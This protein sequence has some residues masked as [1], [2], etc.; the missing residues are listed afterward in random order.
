[1]MLPGFLRDD[2]DP[3]FELLRQKRTT[4]LQEVIKGLN[5]EKTGQILEE[6]ETF[7]NEPSGDAATAPNAGRPIIDL[8]SERIYK[9]YRRIVKSGK[10]CLTDSEDE[11][12]HALRIECKKLRYLL[13]FF[14]SLFP[15][16]ETNQP[17]RAAE[18]ATE[19]IWE[20]L[21]ICAFSRI[22]C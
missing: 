9:R 6:W 14:A 12:L 2:I 5:S 10:R 16:K 19:P 4:A 1:M 17:D 13:E 8:A 11:M 20:I 21:M 18:E 3:L 22:I 15:A 7:L